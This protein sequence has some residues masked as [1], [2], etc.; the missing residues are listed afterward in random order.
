M[1]RWFLLLAIL[2][3]LFTFQPARAQDEITIQTLDVEI[4]PEYDRPSVLVIYRITL[5]D[6]VKLPAEMVLR[7]PKSAGEPTAI[8]E[9]TTSG[10]YNIAATQAGEEGGSTLYR[11]TTTLP[12]LQMEYYDP[13]LSKDGST[14]SYTFHWSGDYPVEN[15]TISVQQPR[16]A[17]DLHLIP[18]T[19]VSGPASDGL[20][21]FNVPVGD[22]SAGTTFSLDITYEKNDDTLTQPET[23]EAVTPV[24]PVQ[25]A[26]SGR[27]TLTELIPWLLGGVV[28]LLIAV[29]VVWYMRTGRQPDFS[30]ARSQRALRNVAASNNESSAASG[31]A[32]FCHQCGKRA[33]P[34]DNFCR[35]CGAKLRRS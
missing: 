5:A 22:V 17:T 20:T 30:P 1:R 15:L 34:N 4:W 7:V 29:G 23:F 27:V 35:A 33:G 32:V 13:A 2:L 24:T 25:Q 18:D 28:L 16:T 21:Y 12:Q 8:A 19:G 3:S 14:R 11:F 26:A 6:D 10:L 31:G 9:Q